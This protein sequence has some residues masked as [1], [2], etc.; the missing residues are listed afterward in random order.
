M[1]LR[2]PT[3]SPRL[4]AALLALV[5]ACAS[6]STAAA[7]DHEPVT[8]VRAALRERHLLQDRVTRLRAARAERRDALISRPSY[9]AR[10][11]ARSGPALESSDLRHL[12]S[13]SRADRARLGRRIRADHRTVA[14]RIHAIQDRLDA[15]A[16]WLATAG[17]FRACPVPE[18]TVIHDNF[19]ITVRLPGVPVHRHQGD[20][21]EAP[22]WSPIVA[23]FDG[24]AS[25]SRSELGGL[26]VRVRGESGYV[27]NAHLVGYARLGWVQT[28]DVI[29][30]VGETGDATGPHDHLEWHPWNSVASDPYPLLAAACVKS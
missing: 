23:P 19:G 10:A 20:D 13:R 21:V 25:A 24:Y 6:A 14:E 30:Y 5:L 16:W 11:T 26:E 12:R 27:Y 8:A 29:G 1:P 7:S 9:L 18:A 17:V 4:L 28:G 3:R 2:P 15:I 22:S